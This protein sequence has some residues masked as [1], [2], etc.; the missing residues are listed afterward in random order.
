MTDCKCDGNIK[1]YYSMEEWECINKKPDR[2]YGVNKMVDDTNCIDICEAVENGYGE[3]PDCS[4][5]KK[6]I[7][8]EK[9]NIL[10][11]MLFLIT[12]INE[13]N[14]LTS[15]L[16]KPEY[17]QE[18]KDGMTTFEKNLGVDTCTS[19]K[20]AKILFQ[21]SLNLNLADIVNIYATVLYVTFKDT[22]YFEFNEIYGAMFDLGCSIGQI[23]IFEQD[24]LRKYDLGI[25]DVTNENLLTFMSVINF[26][27][28]LNITFSKIKLLINSNKKLILGINYV[29]GDEL[30]GEG[31]GQYNSKYYYFYLIKLLKTNT[32]ISSI[33]L[34]NTDIDPEIMSHYNLVMDKL[35][36]GNIS[37]ENKYL[38]YKNKYLA[39]KAK[40]NL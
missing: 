21:G 17:L 16:I 2:K 25:P 13:E 35:N 26:I 32:I 3:D 22:E 27:E 40:L 8:S 10:K 23:N 7:D 19:L 20:R 28:L 36:T 12:N 6:T 38:K 14:K 30:G 9:L 18:Y 39:L 33:L 4:S 11:I 15:K 24:V 37:F 34:I 1:K 31:I 29:Q 5:K